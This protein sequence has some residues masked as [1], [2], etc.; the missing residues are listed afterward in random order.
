MRAAGRMEIAFARLACAGLC[1]ALVIAGAG[2]R[3]SVSQ[4][5]QEEE[6]QRESAREI[7]RHIEQAEVQARNLYYQGK[8]KQKQKQY[9]D[10]LA[11]WAE[12]VRVD[13]TKQIELPV[14]LAK[15]LMASDMIETA[16]YQMHRPFEN[17]GY[18]RSSR[19]ILELMID[20]KN[21]FMEKHVKKAYEEI[22]QWEWIK[23]GWEKYYRAQQLIE[24]HE[25]ADGLNLLEDIVANYP[26]TPLADQAIL[27]LRQKSLKHQ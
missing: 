3:K 2:C 14:D 26:R 11:L 1:L 13:T 4:V 10:A 16:H 27:L 19:A 23:G 15:N 17:P 9:A 18:P 22:D 6:A 24:S 20:E 7:Q 8:E 21:G 25:L 5:E 12:A